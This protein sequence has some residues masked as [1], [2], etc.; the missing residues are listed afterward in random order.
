MEEHSMVKVIHGANDGEF[1]FAGYTVG[2]IRASLDV[3]FNIPFDAAAFVNGEAVEASY[4]LAPN[5]CL[6]FVKQFG[7]KGLGELLTPVE[8]MARWRLTAEQYQELQD[9]GLPTITFADGT[10]RQPGSFP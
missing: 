9:R 3:A 6:E 5:D 4:V 7:F 2:V 8:I 1:D 10:A